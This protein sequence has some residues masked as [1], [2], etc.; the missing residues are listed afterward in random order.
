MRSLPSFLLTLFFL[1]S[2]LATLDFFKCIS[3]Q[4]RLKEVDC[5]TQMLVCAR[6]NKFKAGK[7]L[8]DIYSV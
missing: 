2:Y 5:S 4:A 7:L 6:N 1:G 3:Y 8:Y